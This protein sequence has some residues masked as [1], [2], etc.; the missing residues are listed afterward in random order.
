[1][2]HTPI[3]NTERQRTGT[4]PS[5]GTESISRELESVKKNGDL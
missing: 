3:N 4:V 1:M 2:L 5:G